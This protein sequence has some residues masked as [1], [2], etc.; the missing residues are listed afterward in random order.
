MQSYTK[1]SSN[2]NSK[3]NSTTSR[4]HQ[5]TDRDWNNATLCADIRLSNDA[6]GAI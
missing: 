4:I 3:L 2:K 5:A 1:Y 6:I